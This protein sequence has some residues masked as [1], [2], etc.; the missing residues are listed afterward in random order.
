[1]GAAQSK[2]LISLLLLLQC[3]FCSFAQ[4]KKESNVWDRLAIRTIEFKERPDTNEHHLR[5]MIPDTSLIELLVDYKKK[6]KIATYTE[7]R[8]GTKLRKDEFVNSWVLPKPDTTSVVDPITGQ[9]LIAIME[10]DPI[11]SK[12]WLLEKWTF[13]TRTGN[14][15]IQILAIAPTLQM[16]YDNG[17]I[18]TH[19]IFWMKY[20]DVKGILE[21][22]EQQHPLH[23][24]SGQIWNDYFLNGT[25]PSAL[26]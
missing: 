18:T 19:P 7:A 10:H 12:Y 8:D 17:P 2:L 22:Y 1:M 3:P 16:Q 5:S 9:E 15:R 24:I 23:T 4:V 13:N 26:K 14:T 21:Q 11:T 25:K 20:D 6:G